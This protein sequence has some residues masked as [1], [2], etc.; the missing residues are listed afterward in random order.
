VSKE[1]TVEQLKAWAEELVREVAR[2]SAE[3]A[4]DEGY[5]ACIHDPIHGPKSRNPYRLVAKGGGK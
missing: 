1:T 2:D 3:K 4:W 5:T